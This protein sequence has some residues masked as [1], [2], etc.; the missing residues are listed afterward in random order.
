MPKTSRTTKCYKNEVPNIVGSIIV[1][2]HCVISH[3]YIFNICEII[4]IQTKYQT[5]PCHI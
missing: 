1:A 3:H 4:I 5:S 2:E